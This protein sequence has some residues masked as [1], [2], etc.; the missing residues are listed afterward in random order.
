[1]KSIMKTLVTMVALELFVMVKLL[2]SPTSVLGM[3]N[4]LSEPSLRRVLTQVM[5]GRGRPS[6]VQVRESEAGA[7]SSTVLA[8]V[9]VMEGATA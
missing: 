6:A 4:T 5:V 8:G 3:E 1:M 2:P 9:T 7:S